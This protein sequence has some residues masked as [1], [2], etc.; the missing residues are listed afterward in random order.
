MNANP[1]LYI[2]SITYT[3]PLDLIDKHIETHKEFL[4][5]YYDNGSF[6]VSG[7]KEPRTGGVI[8]ARVKNLATLND[9]LKEDNFFKNEFADYHITEFK[10]TMFCADFKPII[11]V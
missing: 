11:N 8:I 9:I 6:I 3:V 7:R 2:I 1:S 10:P 4:K 5:K